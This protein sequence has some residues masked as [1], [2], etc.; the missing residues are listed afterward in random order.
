M[1]TS[2]VDRILVALKTTV[3]NVNSLFWQDFGRFESYSSHLWEL[4][5]SIATYRFKVALKATLSQGKIK[6]CS[7]LEAHLKSGSGNQIVNVGY[8]ELICNMVAFFKYEQMY[9]SIQMPIS[10]MPIYRYRYRQRYRHR[11]RYR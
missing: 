5:E 11:Y 6:G 8:A 10:S 2:T 1:S 3:M 7:C 9:T 4:T